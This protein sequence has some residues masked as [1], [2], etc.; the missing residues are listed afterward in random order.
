MEYCPDRKQRWNAYVGH[1]NTGAKA[2]IKRFWG[3]GKNPK[4]FHIYAWCVILG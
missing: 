3:E 2:G 1:V 4:Y